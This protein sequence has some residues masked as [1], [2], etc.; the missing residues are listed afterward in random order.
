MDFSRVTQAERERLYNEV[1]TDPVTTVAKRYHMSDNG[2]RKHCKRLW[3]PLPPS[4]YWA[5]VKAGQKV[6]KP[7]L[8]KV[9]GELKR[10]VHSYFIKYRPDIDLLTDEELRS[11]AGLGLLTDDTVSLIQET[12]AQIKV[13]NQLRNPHHLITEHKEESSY[14]KK[15]DK[16]LRQASSNANY[17]NITKS[18]YRDNKAMLPI[19]VS[20]LNLNRAYRILDTLMQ[21]LDDMEGYTRVS[22]DSGKDKAYFVVMHTAFYFELKEEK[23]KKRR[24]SNGEEALPPLVLSLLAENWYYSSI[25]HALEYKDNDNEPLEDQVGHIMLE[26]FQTANGMMIEE[27][28]SEREHEREMEEMERQRL[29]EQ[30]RRGELAEIKL[31]EQAA[32]DWA[33]A[34]RIRSFANELEAKIDTV[35]DQVKKEKLLRWLKWSR[36][37]ADWLDPL[38]DKEDELLGKSTHIFE[39][40]Y[41]TEV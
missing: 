19:N 25:Q 3:I 29:L 6:S 2:L 5:R 10:Y 11:L 26:L 40:I 37:K 33:K 21:A 24:S 22:L 30:M 1:W 18:K 12:C 7:D 41:R 15:R 31:L 9:R 13:K 23:R 38:T 16:A 14:R 20:E 39:Q 4:G 34:Q 28:L 17:L 35:S 8:P 32:S 27:K 36:D